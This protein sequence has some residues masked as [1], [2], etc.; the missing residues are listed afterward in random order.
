MTILGIDPGTRRIGYG[1]I[2][3]LPGKLGFVSAG[4]LKIKGGD[5]FSALKETRRQIEGIIGKFK[6]EILAIEKLYFMRNQKTGIQVAQA[7]GVI[8]LSAL[9]KGLKILEY[10]PNE[11]K[12]GIT[13][14]G[15]ADKKAVL[16][17]VKLILGKS[18]LDIVDDASDALAVAI[19]ASQKGR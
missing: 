10:A 7:R 9:E 2:K 18:D 16:K 1:V 19:L 5:D 14:Y 11:I 12:A 3:K 6:P 4:L 15:F 8:L 13:G 17:M